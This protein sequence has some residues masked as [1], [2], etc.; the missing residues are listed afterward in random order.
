MQRPQDREYSV[1]PFADSKAELAVTR[2]VAHTHCN[3]WVREVG[4]Q[5]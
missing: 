5:Y 2:D 1:R 3:F 4:S